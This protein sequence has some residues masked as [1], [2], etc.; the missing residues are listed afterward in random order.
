MNEIATAIEEAEWVRVLKR[1]QQRWLI[2]VAG[3]E[4]QAHMARKG[5]NWQLKI[6]AHVVANGWYAVDN[7]ELA[8]TYA[9]L[10]VRSRT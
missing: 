6:A 8:R 9:A 10:A 1:G 3:F 4:V 7:K 2:Q 5:W